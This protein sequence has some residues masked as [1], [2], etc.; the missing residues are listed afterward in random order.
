MLK[1]VLADN[2]YLEDEKLVIPTAA[3]VGR[4]N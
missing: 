4:M 2:L 3:S 1:Y